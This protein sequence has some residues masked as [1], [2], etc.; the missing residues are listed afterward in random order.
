MDSFYLEYGMN[1]RS[2]LLLASWQVG[3]N[4]RKL[5]QIGASSAIWRKL[6]QVDANRRELTKDGACAVPEIP[7]KHLV[8]PV[9]CLHRTLAI[10][11]KSIAPYC[12]ETRL[13]DESGPIVHSS[14]FSFSCPSENF[15]SQE[16]DA[17]KQKYTVQ[18]R[19]DCVYSTDVT[20]SATMAT[21]IWRHKP[22]HSHA[23]C[24]L[25]ATA[26]IDFCT[27]S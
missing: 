2:D 4:W 20:D 18:R 19:V 12:A 1:W 10:F 6:A 8:A 15:D 11:C 7:A 3:A 23:N 27:P 25:I 5:T 9:R 24:S 13:T 16:R 17:I 22:T 21:T 26:N 14:R